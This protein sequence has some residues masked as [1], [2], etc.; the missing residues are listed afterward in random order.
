MEV[1][2]HHL[3]DYQVKKDHITR[4][5]ACSNTSFKQKTVNSLMAVKDTINGKIFNSLIAVNDTINGKIFNSLM[6]IHNTINKKIFN[7]INAKSASYDCE[8]IKL[9]E[10]ATR[11]RDINTTEL[12]IE[13]EVLLGYRFQKK[14]YACLLL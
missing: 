6:A 14:A 13:R 7:S 9:M 4:R 3:S 11:F 5:V 1:L 12:S 2:I 10:W 8:L